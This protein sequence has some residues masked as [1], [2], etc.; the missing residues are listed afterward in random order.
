[1]HIDEIAEVNDQLS[2][3]LGDSLRYPDGTLHWPGRHFDI[4]GL[5][6]RELSI[7]L[8]TD[9]HFFIMGKLGNLDGSVDDVL[10]RLIEW[11]HTCYMEILARWA[12]LHADVLA[13][14]VEVG[15]AGVMGAALGGHPGRVH[16]GRR[17]IS[18]RP[19]H[20]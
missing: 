2:W 3:G 19:T 12:P 6:C 4:D 18:R 5:M 1:M 10:G 16:G 8:S 9:G 15:R 11:A 17:S 20:A 7:T 14:V 13:G